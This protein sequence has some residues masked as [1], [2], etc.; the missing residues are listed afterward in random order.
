MKTIWT[1]SFRSESGDRFDNYAQFDHEPNE[2]EMKRLVSSNNFNDD[3]WEIANGEGPGIFGS[4]LF[5]N[6]QK[7]E[8]P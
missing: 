1:V 3:G 5:P 2:A 6:I 8:T 4:Y 7:V